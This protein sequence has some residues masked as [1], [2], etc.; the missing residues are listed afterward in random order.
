MLGT[1]TSLARPSRAGRCPWGCG[2]ALRVSGAALRVRRVLGGCTVDTLRVC[3]YPAVRL[4]SGALTMP[5]ATEHPGAAQPANWALRHNLRSAPF[6]GA[7]F[8]R[9]LWLIPCSK[10]QVLG[11]RA[12]IVE[13]MSLT[14]GSD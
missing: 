13:K 9:D 2:G 14:G 7:V 5:S 10:T 6:I 11:A 12:A 1:G 4:V 3:V 8:C